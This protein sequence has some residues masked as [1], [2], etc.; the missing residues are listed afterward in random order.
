VVAR[1]YHL[2]AAAAPRRRR[3]WLGLRILFFYNIN[4]GDLPTP[5]FQQAPMLPI[6]D[7][8]CV[9]G[10]I[11]PLMSLLGV[12]AVPVVNAVTRSL[13]PTEWSRPVRI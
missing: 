12:H 8:R 10:Q 3:R 9:H 7:I 4:I 1:R 13:K 11:L 2:V 5:M 6:F